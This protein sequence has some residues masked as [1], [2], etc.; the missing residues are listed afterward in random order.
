MVA[1][2]MLS[3]AALMIHFHVDMAEGFHISLM[4]NM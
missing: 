4:T 2:K 1:K 3:S